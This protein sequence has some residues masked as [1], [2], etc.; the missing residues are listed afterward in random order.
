MAILVAAVAHFQDKPTT[1][2]TSHHTCWCI[3]WCSSHFAMLSCCH[4]HTAEHYFQYLSMS[5]INRCGW[6]TGHA[7]TAGESCSFWDFHRFCPWIITYCKPAW[8]SHPSRWTPCCPKAPHSAV[9]QVRSA[10]CK[11]WSMTRQSMQL[12]SRRSQMGDKPR[13]SRP[14]L[15]AS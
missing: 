9:H 3:C 15:E 4:L 10:R 7:G 12:C 5:Y 13:P 11:R 1:Y 14:P 8:R 2:T 6:F